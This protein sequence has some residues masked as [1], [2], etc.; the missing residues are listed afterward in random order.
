MDLGIYIIHGACMAAGGV[1]PVAVTAREIAKTKPKLF[2]EVEEGM[3]WTMEFAD[4]AVC[5]AFTSYTHS[6]DTFRAESPR[7]WIEFKEHAFTYRGMV[8]DTS[9]GPLH[10]DPPV[11]QQA[12][13][14]D[15]FAQCIREDRDPA[16]AASWG[17]ATW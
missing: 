3:N 14:M 5:E 16:L 6:A 15:D 7:G 10:F 13:Q 8:V 9:R 17:A 11:N 2:P 1:A 4:G 12:L